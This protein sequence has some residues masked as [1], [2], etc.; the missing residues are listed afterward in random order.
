MREGGTSGLLHYEPFS[1]RFKFCVLAPLK[2]FAD[3]NPSF[4]MEMGPMVLVLDNVHCVSDSGHLR[5]MLDGLSSPDAMAD[6]PPF[7]KIVLIGRSC[8][9]ILRHEEFRQVA[10]IQE[11]ERAG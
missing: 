5:E 7:L 10:D 6:F 9:P 4:R 8:Q 11:L 1:E 2:E 3:Q